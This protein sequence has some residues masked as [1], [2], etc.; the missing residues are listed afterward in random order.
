MKDKIDKL[1]DDIQDL[2]R[3]NSMLKKEIEHAKVTQE[4]NEMKKKLE[5]LK[6]PVVLDEESIVSGPAVNPHSQ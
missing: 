5:A 2:D 6:E 4:L 1:E 3:T